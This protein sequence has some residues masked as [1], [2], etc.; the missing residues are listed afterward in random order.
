MLKLIC[1]CFLF[2]S[3]NQRKTAFTFLAFLCLAITIGKGE[4]ERR[5]QPNRTPKHESSL[6][7]AKEQWLQMMQL[8]DTNLDKST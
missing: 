5:Y 3:S 2:S 1:F 4:E 7:P 8:L 6:C